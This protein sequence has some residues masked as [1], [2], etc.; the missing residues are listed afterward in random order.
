M[1]YDILVL[2]F[3]M[4]EIMRKERGVPFDRP[5]DFKGPY[6]SAD[7]CILLDVAARLGMRCCLIGTIGQDPFGRLVMRRLES[8]GVDTA[9]AVRIPN[10]NTAVVF[11]RY[12]L[13]G[14]REYA[15]MDGDTASCYLTEDDIDSELVSR[16]RWVHFSG[17]VI[18]ICSDPVRRKAILKMLA[19][20]PPQTK[21]SLDPNYVVLSEQIQELF[22]PFVARAD[23]ILPSE[24]EARYLL[25][26]NT[27]EES[28]ERLSGQ[29]KIIAYKRGKQG[30]DLYSNGEV[31]HVDAYK[32]EEVD[33]TGCGDSYCAGLITGLLEGMP[34]YEAGRLASACGALQAT[35]LGPMEGAFWRAEVDRFMRNDM[36]KEGRSI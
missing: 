12:D 6:P 8:D 9:H 25:G 19:S 34:L 31:I 17:E 35:V 2:G 15:N 23:L 3:P 16:A 30:S 5:A 14:A 22:A 20:I 28:L 11:V 29:G 13:D 1:L 4:V 18:M 10:K 26:T 32:V 7:T 24:G 27:E 21:V 36:G 33:P